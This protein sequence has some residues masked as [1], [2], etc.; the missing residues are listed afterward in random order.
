MRATH[1]LVS[2]KD[3]PQ[4][5]IQICILFNLRISNLNGWWHRGLATGLMA[6]HRSS[7]G[8]H[9]SEHRS[10]LEGD[11]LQHRQ[12]G[13]L[14]FLV[15]WGSGVRM[16]VLLV[17]SRKGKG[18]LKD[19]WL[20]SGDCMRGLTFITSRAQ[21]WCGQVHLF[22]T[23]L[24]FWKQGDLHICPVCLRFK[25]KDGRSNALIRQNNVESWTMLRCNE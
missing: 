24:A 6:P 10:S 21:A 8:A 23:E 25:G 1:F 2:I 13:A 18:L 16:L 3:T 5:S 7:G 19:V 4:E 11:H 22:G 20:W 14:V 9:V 15:F 12:R 17:R